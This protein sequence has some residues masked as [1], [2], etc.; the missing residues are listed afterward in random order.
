MDGSPRAWKGSKD[1]S[2]YIELAGVFKTQH[3]FLSLQKEEM[4]LSTTWVD[5]FVV[6]YL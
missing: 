1:K 2:D 5:I 3:P 4:I 6:D